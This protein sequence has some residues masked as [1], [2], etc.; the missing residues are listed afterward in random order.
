MQNKV[1]TTLR[2]LAPDFYENRE[3][4]YKKLEFIQ[5]FFAYMGDHRSQ[6][7]YLY[8]MITSA[9]KPE[10]AADQVLHDIHLGLSL[11]SICSRIVDL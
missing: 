5:F 11:P 10:E 4:M 8:K 6:I 2:D 9:L 3:T 1:E 7:M